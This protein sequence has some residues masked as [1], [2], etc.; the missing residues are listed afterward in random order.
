[1]VSPEAPDDESLRIE[2][3]EALVTYRQYISQLVQDN[4]IF[5]AAD[6]ALVS[7]ALG[8][9]ADSLLCWNRDSYCAL[10]IEPDDFPLPIYVTP[11]CR[12][13][14]DQG[15]SQG[16][17][18]AT[19][20]PTYTRAS[21]V[22]GLNPTPRKPGKPRRSSARRNEGGRPTAASDLNVHAPHAAHLALLVSLAMG[23]VTPAGC[24][25]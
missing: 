5:V 19:D 20:D 6:V 15:W 18:G 2:L 16:L 3:Q 10:Y 11:I 17:L 22:A 9:T 13:D 7:I 1:M 8:G 24:S 12:C 14:Q 23:P 21:K 25:V 4:G